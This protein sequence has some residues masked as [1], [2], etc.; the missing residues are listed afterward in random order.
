MAGGVAR[1][2]AHFQLGFAETQ[3]LA[4]RQVGTF[5]DFAMFSLYPTKNMT[6]GEGG[7]ISCASDEIVRLARLY[8]NQGMEKQY[9]NEVV[10]FNCRMT[11]IHAAIGRVQ[12]TKVDDWTQTRQ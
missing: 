7:M 11:D 6:S 3:R 1:G 2:E 10:G 9:H 8:R 5:G 4:G 12:L